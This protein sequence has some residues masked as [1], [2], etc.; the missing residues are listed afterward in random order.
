MVERLMQKWGTRIG[1]RQK[2][3]EGGLTKVKGLFFNIFL[4]HIETC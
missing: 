4:T 1:E 3:G 2:G